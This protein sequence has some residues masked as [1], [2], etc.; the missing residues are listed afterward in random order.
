MISGTI[1]MNIQQLQ[2][3]L[4]SLGSDG[5]NIFPVLGLSLGKIRYRGTDKRDHRSELIF[6]L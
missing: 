3:D 1:S 4:E 6:L 2:V 5:V